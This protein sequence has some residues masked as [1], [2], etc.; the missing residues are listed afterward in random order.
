MAA[1]VLAGPVRAEAVAAL[2]NM[3]ISVLG[4]TRERRAEDHGLSP[5]AAGGGLPAPV[6]DGAGPRPRRVHDAPVRAGRRGGPAR[7]VAGGRAGHRH[8]PGDLG[9]VRCKADRVQ[10]PG[11]VSYTHL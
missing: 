4:G 11:A 1:A 3:T 10:G 2:A 8:R 9:P 5:G 6:L 7:L